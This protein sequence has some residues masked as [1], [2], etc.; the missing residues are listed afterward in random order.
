[1][2]QLVKSGHIFLETAQAYNAQLKLHIIEELFIMGGMKCYDCSR[3]VGLT[4]IKVVE[5]VKSLP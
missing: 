2:A 3:I 1:M 5:K 4:V